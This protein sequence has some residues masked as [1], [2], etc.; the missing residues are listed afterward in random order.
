[1]G[2]VTMHNPQSGVTREASEAAYDR[3]YAKEGWQLVE[4]PKP[5]RS[6]PPADPNAVP[7]GSIDDDVDWVRGGPA[8]TEATDGWR[9]R[10]QQALEAEQAKG[11]RARKTLVDRLEEILTSPE[12]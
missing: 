11:D 9:E 3:T 7:S 4:Q 6:K 2:K 8:G 1:M 5:A 12:A 10:A